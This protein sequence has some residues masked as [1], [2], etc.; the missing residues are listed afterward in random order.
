MTQDAPLLRLG[1][2][3]SPL[4]LY[5]AEA[6]K[7]RL[8]AAHPELAKPGALEIVIISNNLGD[9]KSIIT[10]PTT[11]THQRLTD[12]QRA[13]LGITPGLVRLSVG[14]EDAEDLI[15]DLMQALEQA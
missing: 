3:G 15:A 5:Q 7:A 10:H 2:R 14:I 1:T 4:A 13:A 12:D 9:A 8:E 11:T 6:V